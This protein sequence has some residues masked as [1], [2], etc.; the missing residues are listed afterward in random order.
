[1]F[2]Q[3]GKGNH[4]T[5]SNLWSGLGH[6]LETGRPV[7]ETPGPENKIEQDVSEVTGIP[8]VKLSSQLTG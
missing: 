3:C 6:I 7:E 4:V 1:M 5:T 2:L 8:T